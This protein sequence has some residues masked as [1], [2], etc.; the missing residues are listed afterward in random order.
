M[1]VFRQIFDATSEFLEARGVS[2]DLF[3]G[4]EADQSDIDA[5]NSDA[6]TL[7]PDTFSRFFTELGDGFEFGWEDPEGNAFGHF[8]MPTLG[9]LRTKQEWWNENIQDFLDD[10]NS[11][12]R[13]IKPQFRAQAF[14]I[15]GRMKGWIPFWEEGNGDH[16]CVDTKTG[17]IVYDQH[18]WF[19]GFGSLAKTNGIVAGNNLVN[20]L[21]NWSRFCFQSNKDLWWGE[22]SEF[23]AIRW[24]PQYF[25]ARFYRGG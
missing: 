20:F 10:A 5:F 3:Q 14:A 16:F 22:F 8:S 12:D 19:D 25:D 15:W 1:S 2:P 24:E 6:D 9:E 18:D 7:L 11:L 17:Q 4:E 13:C 21:E 23:G